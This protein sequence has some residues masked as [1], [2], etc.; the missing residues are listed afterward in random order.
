[1]H[2]GEIGGLAALAEDGEAGLG[3]G[4]ADRLDEIP[5]PQPGRHLDVAAA[6]DPRRRVVEQ[7]PAPRPCETRAL[8]VVPGSSSSSEDRAPSRRLPLRSAGR[9]E[10]S[11]RRPSTWTSWIGIFSRSAAHTPWSQTLSA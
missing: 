1:M 11:L 3:L 8:L 4:L 5:D 2:R 9:L 10:V 7:R 6:D